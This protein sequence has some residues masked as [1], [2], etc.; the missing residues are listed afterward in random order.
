MIVASSFLYLN[1]RPSLRM[2]AYT[3]DYDGYPIEWLD[4]PEE[5]KQQYGQRGFPF[6]F[7]WMFPDYFKTEIHEEARLV[8][9]F[10]D[11]GIGIGIV[12]AVGIFLEVLIRRRE[13]QRA[14]ATNPPPPEK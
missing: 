5:S 1:C 10:C 14:A 6:T 11:V 8:P 13:R 4:A 12:C 2:V 3:L 9:L 7:Q